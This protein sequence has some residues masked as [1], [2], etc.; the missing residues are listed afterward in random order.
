MPSRRPITV[1]SAAVAGG[2][3]RL[4]APGLLDGSCLSA[5]EG[6]VLLEGHGDG[7]TRIDQADATIERLSAETERVIAPF[8]PAVTLLMTIPGVHRRLVAECGADMGRFRSAA[9]LASWAGMC[10][11]NNESAGKD[12]SGKTRKG[13]KWLRT[14]L[15]EAARAAALSRGNYLA[16]QYARLRPRRG[17]NKAAVA[18]AHSILVIAWHILTTAEPYRDLGPLLPRTPTQRGIP[19]AP[20]RPARAHG[21]RRHLEQ[22]PAA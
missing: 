5:A 17:P 3:G 22:R 21:L 10:P 7:R 14:T 19:P 2:W 13:S 11:G 12:R 6:R 9:H 18:V 8:E 1:L 15:V 4:H 16:A 20:G